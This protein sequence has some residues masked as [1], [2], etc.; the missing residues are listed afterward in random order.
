MPIARES[1]KNACPMATMKVLA[2]T[3]EKSGLKRKS[4]PSTKPGRK[5]LLT[6][7]IRRSTQ[8]KGII[9]LDARSMPFW[10]PATMMAAL[11]ATLITSHRRGCQGLVLKEAKSLARTVAASTEG[12]AACAEATTDAKS[13]MTARNV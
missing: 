2:E 7:S 9:T 12:S 8:S 5:K 13:L 4:H 3:F 6:T 1:E 10:T 11:A